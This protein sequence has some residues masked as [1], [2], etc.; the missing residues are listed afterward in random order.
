M[1]PIQTQQASTDDR[2]AVMSYSNK[3]LEELLKTDQAVFV[4]MTA[5]WCITCKV[6]ERVALNTDSIQDIFKEKDIAYLKGDWTNQDPGITKYLQSHGRSGVPLYVYYPAPIDGQRPGAI[7]LPQILTP[8][9]VRDI[10]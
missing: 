7:I 9:I 10:L 5:S 8:A 2:V 6:N 1:Q 3:K 4:N